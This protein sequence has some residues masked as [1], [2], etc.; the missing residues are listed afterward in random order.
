MNKPKS[1]LREQVVENSFWSIFSIIISRAGG[2]IFTIIISRTLMPE[3]FGIY[4]FAM[5]LCL[6][7]IT[8]ADAG[9]NQTLIRYISCQTGKNQEKAASHFRYLFKIKIFLTFFISLA[10]ILIAYPLSFYILKNS[11]LFLPVII[12]SF[13]VF[14]IS[15]AGF[16]ESLFFIKKNVKYLSIKEAIFQ[17]ARIFIALAVACL[18]AQKFKVISLSF[19]SLIISIPILF[20]VVYLSKKLFP[21]IFRKT[22]ER[23]SKKK[24]LNFIFLLNIEN[25]CFSILVQASIIFLGFFLAS[26]Y[27]GYYN[28]ALVIILAISSLLTFTQILLPVLTQLK[29]GSFEIALQ[30]IFRILMML[31]IPLSF[32]LA[33]LAKYFIVL[34]YGYPYLPAALPLSVLA[35]LIIPYI[36]TNL[37][38]TCFSAKGKPKEFMKIMIVSTIV[39]LIL[40][41]V[42]IK[43]F[44][45]ISPEM[46]LLGAA[47]AHLASWLFYL[48][49]SA[50][51]LNK[52]LKINIFSAWLIKPIISGLVM[53]AFI[54]YILRMLKD[55]NVSNGIFIVLSGAA[56]YFLAMMLLKGLRKEELNLFKEIKVYKS[57]NH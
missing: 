8:F 12:L 22:Q 33:V 38:L 32:G 54:I 27:V 41:Y 10:L 49:L 13:Y 36:S 19:L 46:A 42:F 4:A 43:S 7:V 52:K 31:A 20:F 16:F 9:I 47:I 40:N 25:I 21:F 39:Y 57:K 51:L 53:S 17:T 24:V 30:K 45:A 29:S 56:V 1:N 26:A 50:W 5:T 11:Q 34:I 15:L 35:F 28:S 6:F 37:F 44:L 23:I 3:G 2:F 48:F 55:I 18:I 14:F